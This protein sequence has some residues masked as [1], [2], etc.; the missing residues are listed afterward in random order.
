MG[1]GVPEKYYVIGYDI[2]GAGLIL[3]AGVNDPTGLFLYGG[4]N[5]ERFDKLEIAIG[6][7]KDLNEEP[8]SRYPGSGPW[9]VYKMSFEPVGKDE[10]HNLLVEASI[11]GKGRSQ[12]P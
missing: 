3:Y 9:Q 5:H 10:T 11:E 12:F 7:A 2:P 6:V 8:N 1:F 4:V